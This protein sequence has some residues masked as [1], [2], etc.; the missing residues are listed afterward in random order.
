[1]S[2]ILN[3]HSKWDIREYKCRRC[4]DVL[5]ESGCFRHPGQKEIHMR[6]AW[7][8]E[9]YHVQYLYHPA[10]AKKPEKAR[11]IIS[12]DVFCKCDR[13]GK[14]SQFIVST[15]LNNPN[16]GIKINY[17]SLSSGQGRLHT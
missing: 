4:G 10:D 3:T 6:N 13:C 15:V 11:R 12:I 16:G 1:V 17:N 14:N 9:N 5:M 2:I 7:R 8:K